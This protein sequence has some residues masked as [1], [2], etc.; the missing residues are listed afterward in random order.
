LVKRI[1]TAIPD[2]SLTT[3]IILGF[4]GETEED[5]LETI[6]IV[7]KVGFDSAFTFAYSKRTGTPAAT[8]ENQVEEAV[9]KERF[10]RLLEEVHKES[11]KAAGK[12]EHT[13]QKVLVEEVNSQDTSLLT[14]RMSNNVLV[15]FK[16]DKNLIGKIVEVYLKES[17]GFYYMGELKYPADFQI[18]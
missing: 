7:K 15:H 2:I 9:I 6:D 14:G 17:K 16:G 11:A 10:E 3:D 5:F 12:D 8:M 13:I 4:P 1:R 18:I